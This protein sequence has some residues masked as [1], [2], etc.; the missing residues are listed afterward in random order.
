MKKIFQILCSLVCLLSI[1]SVVMSSCN[2]ASQPSQGDPGSGNSQGAVNSDGKQI[3]VYEGMSILTSINVPK[4]TFADNSSNSKGKENGNTDNN[5]KHNGWYKGDSVDDQEDVNQDEPFPDT[6]ENVEEEIKDSLEVIGSNGEL[7]YATQNSDVYV[8][9]YINNPDNFEIL[10][11]TLNGKKYSSYMFEYGSTLEVLILKLNVGDVSGIVEYTIDQIKYVDGTEIKDVTIAGDQTVEVGVRCEDQVT[12]IVSGVQIDTNSIS[13][14]ANISDKDGLIAYSKGDIKAVLYDGDKLIAEKALA[15]GDNEIVFDGLKNGTVYQYAIVASYNDCTGNKIGYHLLAKEAFKTNNIVLFD[16][17]LVTQDGINFTFKWDDSVTNKSLTTL[18]LYKNGA[19]V[20]ELDVTAT[21]V[22]GILSA[23]EYSIVAEYMD[24]GKTESIYLD[25]ITFAKGTPN[26]SIVNATST[27][28]SIGFGISESDV[29]NI[30]L[31]TKIELVHASGTVVAENVDIRNFNN[32]I[33]NNSYTVKVTYTYDLGDGNGAQTI[34]ASKVVKTNAKAEPSVAIQNLSFTLTSISGECVVTD[35]DSVVLSSKVALYLGDTLI[36]ESANGSFAFA[37]LK[38]GSIY[39]IKVVYIY[40]LNDGQGA[41]ECV[42]VKDVCCASTGLNYTISGGSVRITGIGTCT[43]TVLYIPSVIDGYKVTAIGARAFQNCA[44]FTSVII[45][46]SVTS[47]GENAFLDCPSVTSVAIGDSVTSI[48]YQAFGGCYSLTSVVIPD[49][50]ISIGN[51][52][53]QYCSGITSVVIGNSVTSIGTH[54]FFGCTELASVTIPSSVT[55]IGN[56]AFNL[57]ESCESVYITDIEAWCNISFA[58]LSPANPMHYGADLYLN[59]ELVT[60]LIIPNTMTSIKDFAFDGCQSLTSVVIPDSVTSIGKSAFSGCSSLES[61]VIPDSVTSIGDRAFYDC[62]SLASVYITDIES[63]YNISFYHYYSNPMYNGANLYLNGE[64]VT[65]INIKNTVFSIKK[66]AFYGC[67][68]LTSVVIPDSVASIGNGAFYGCSSLESVVIPDSVTS[69]DEGV[70][71]CCD[72][73]T[74]VVIPDSLTSIGKQ[75]F[76]GCSSLESV[77]IPDSVTSIGDEA[78]YCCTSLESVVIPDSVT[79]IG[80]RAFQYCYSLTSVVIPDSVTSIGDEALRECTSL[81]SIIIPDSV[82]SIGN[83]AFW[84][85][86]SLTSVVIPDS[87]TRIGDSAFSCCFSLISVVIPDSV[88][89][90]GDSAF[91][92]CYSLTSV[93]IDNGVTSIGDLAFGWCSSLESVV[94]PESVTRIGEMAFYDCVSLTS[95]KF[96]GTEEQ[97]NAITKGSD[98]DSNTG[99]YTIIYNYT[100]E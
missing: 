57:C 69:I 77:V 29:D 42:V 24:L 92:N 4:T 60:D 6:N 58:A 78:F 61:V 51:R 18:K 21:S 26:V 74:S 63:W 23:N 35:A 12:A 88:T 87:V 13:F 7:F 54:A 47:I 85:C 84:G 37:N 97:W 100:G 14:N 33:S 93:V 98:W 34:T 83:Y 27:Q 48:G 94:I 30:G 31:V 16:N 80:D 22:A 1:V 43:D 8:H 44:S 50:V 49:S 64:L 25:F 41:H 99:N 95:I 89:R 66:Y 86:T 2:W 39:T 9:I 81:T 15:L 20:K 68:S 72:S 90:I 5:G 45:P 67:K 75:A 91:D 3:P 96:R 32:L 28:N 82:T 73:L 79:S 70:F 76:S 53:F 65:D 55:S 10:S 56:Y 52:A 71:A 62:S 11:F 36:A 38:T 19:L 59:G 17:I 46:D 40:D